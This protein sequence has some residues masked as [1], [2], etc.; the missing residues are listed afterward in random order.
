[1][2]DVDTFLTILYVTVDDFGKSQLAAAPRPGPAAALSPSEVITLALFSQWRQFESE[3]AFY[4]YAARHLRAAF[5]TLPDRSQFNR[6]VRT[7][8]DAIVAVALALG[9]QA[10]L[11]SAGYEVLDSMGVPVRNAKRRGRGHL[12]GQAALGWCN[13]V[14][15][16]MG[17]KLLT[18]VTRVGAITGFGLGPGNSGDHLW[19]ETVL[20]ARHQPQPRLPS[21]GH[22]LDDCYIADTGFAGQPIRARWMRAYGG[23]GITQPEQ[24]RPHRW[25]KRLRRWL[26]SL[27]EIVET[28]HDQLLEAFRLEHERPHVLRGV[29]ARLAAKVGLHNF[30]CWLNLQQGRPAL[31][32]ADLL[33]W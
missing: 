20:A 13:R 5:P 11:P 7:H 1:M 29:Q 28:V 18:V 32:V 17:L 16:F 10:S 27:R 22:S 26:A 14:G 3:R 6:L 12:A 9:W 21:A 23:V 15:W 31:A 19:A 33:D 30:C 4:R 24:R 25:P 2:Y 8:H